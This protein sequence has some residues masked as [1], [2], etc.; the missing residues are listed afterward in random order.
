MK[1]F[2]I[3]FCVEKIILIVKQKEFISVIQAGN[4]NP[5]NIAF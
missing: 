2:H 5:E 3:P 1:I 4:A